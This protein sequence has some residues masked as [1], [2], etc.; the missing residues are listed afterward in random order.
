MPVTIADLRARYCWTSSRAASPV[1]HFD[2]P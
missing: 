1:I 2:S